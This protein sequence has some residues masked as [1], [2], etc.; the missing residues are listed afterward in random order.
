MAIVSII[1]SSYRGKG[2][3][4]FVLVKHRGLINM[5]SMKEDNNELKK[6]EKHKLWMNG[7][8]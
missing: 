1:F 3:L 4:Y 8:T 6:R 2:S 7:F 5:E